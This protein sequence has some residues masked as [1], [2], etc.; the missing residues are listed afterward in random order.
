M[1]CDPLVLRVFGAIR[2]GP[3]EYS[4]VVTESNQFG[5]DEAYVRASSAASARVQIAGFDITNVRRHY[6]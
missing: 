4:H 6:S 5:A 2:T 3:G 1:D